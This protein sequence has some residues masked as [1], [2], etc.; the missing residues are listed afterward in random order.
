MTTPSYQRQSGFTLMEVLATLVL[1]GIV[2]PV[3]M[4][5]ISLSLN[6]ASN[7]RRTAEAASLAQGKLNEIIAS[8][9]WQ[10]AG[11]RGD[12]GPDH[13]EYHW[14]AE[15]VNRETGLSEIDLHVSWTGRGSERMLTTSTLIYTPGTQQ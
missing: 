3:A 12:F 8:Q 5:G 2:L 6:A 13:A 10:N 7:A 14:S 11:L 15:V 4:Q 9:Q 1:V